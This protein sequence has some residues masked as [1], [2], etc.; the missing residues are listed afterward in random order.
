MTKK[1]KKSIEDN[2]RIV[3]INRDEY[4]GKDQVV[5]YLLSKMKSYSGYFFISIGPSGSVFKKNPEKKNIVRITIH[6]TIPCMQPDGTYKSAKDIVI[7][8][9]SVNDDNFPGIVIDRHG[10][11]I[12][13]NPFAPIDENK[14][15]NLGDKESGTEV[16]TLHLQ[17]IDEA[18]TLSPEEPPKPTYSEEG[19]VEQ[20]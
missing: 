7:D 8:A 13:G 1:R 18:G 17:I 16:D 20:M 19:T 3:L 14:L 2:T 10:N 9:I 5:A 12:L 15:P 11:G 4:I 6:Q